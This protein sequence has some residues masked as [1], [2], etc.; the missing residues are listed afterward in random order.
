MKQFVA[1]GVG[2]FALVLV[3]CASICLDLPHAAVSFAFGF[4][5]FSMIWAFGDVSG[6]HINPAVTAG[7][8][9]SGNLEGRRVAPYLAAQF[10]GALAAAGVLRV[11]FPVHANLG[12]TL[13]SS[14]WPAL[15]IEVLFTAILVMVILAFAVGLKLRT[16]VVAIV[17]GLTIG[18]ESHL[19]GPISG[20][21]MNP[22]RSVGPALLSGTF[23][24]LWIYL[25]APLVGS[26]IG[27]LAYRVTFP[28]G[29]KGRPVPQP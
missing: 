24:D 12:S 15:G 20:G 23:G 2:T 29:Q 26:V 6:A 17:V 3:G 14:L 9:L 22:A 21:S 7:F 8:W 13:P 4:V 27:A 18:V 25:A 19:G 5:V 11:V 10:A 16:H 28:A 1:E